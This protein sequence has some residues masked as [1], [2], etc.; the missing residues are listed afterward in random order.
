MTSIE[1]ADVAGLIPEDYSNAFLDAIVEQSACMSTFRTIRVGTAVTQLPTL[2]ALPTAGFVTEDS[3]ATGVKPKSKVE[4]SNSTIN[5]AEAAV[6]I[7][8][9]E[10]IIEDSTIDLWAFIRPLVGQ[11][12]GQLIDDAILF[13]TGKPSSW[14]VGLVPQAVSAGS[15][16]T[17]TTD[18]ADAFNDAFAFVEGY[19]H[20][21]NI[22]YAGPAMRARLRGLRTDEGEFLYTDLRGQ[23]GPDYGGSTREM[24]YGA[25]VRTVRNGVWDDSTA[26]AL[27][28]DS[29]KLVIAL[30]SDMQYKLLD[31]ATLGTGESAVN[32][33]ERD[34]VGLRVRARLGWQ[35][36]VNA[37][38]L[39]TSPV[40][41]SIVAPA[42]AS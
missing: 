12:F 36:V 15:V 25:G 6:I 2:S 32:L 17:I 3:G 18:I 42:A 33:A 23:S 16:A 11:A 5:I 19:G 41:F 28:A 38:A 29:S 21:C 7:P 27:C 8:V 9:H 34:M 22:V 4:W 20:D 13:G 31:Q 10:N 35:T 30:R 39:S 24:V 37:N 40:P 1:R 26:L 14:P